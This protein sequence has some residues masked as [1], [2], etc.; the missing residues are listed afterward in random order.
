M[1]ATAYGVSDDGVG[2]MAEVGALYAGTAGLVRCHVRSGVAAS[3]AVIDDAC[4]FAWSR[5]LHHRDRVSGDRVVAWL[6]TTALHEAYKL[7]R[8]AQREVSLE[9]LAAETGDLHLGRG[10]PSP[11]EIVEPRLRLEVLDALPERQR[12]LIWLQGLGFDYGE[13]ATRTGASVRTV[14]RQLTKARRTLRSVEAAE[15]AA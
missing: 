11:P 8:R 6:V 10:A 12:R 13:M 7:T 2:R 14:E 4:Q 9:G 5:L 3:E 1:S 15:G